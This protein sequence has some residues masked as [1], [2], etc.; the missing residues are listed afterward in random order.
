MAYVFAS[1]DGLKRVECGEE[2]WR[3]ALEEAGSLGWSPEGTRF[4]FQYQVEE[5]WDGGLDYAWNLLRMVETH[6]MALGWNGNYTEKENQI[7]SE[8][9]AYELSLYIDSA[10]VGQELLDLLGE[11]AVR[12]V[13]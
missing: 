3:K 1:L 12:I 4:D 11:G 10:I 6:M 8:S 5:I 7:I 9:D 2:E 13:G